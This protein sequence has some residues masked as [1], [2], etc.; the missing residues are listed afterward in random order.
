MATNPVVSL[1]DADQV[2]ARAAR[3]EL[4]IGSDV[5]ANT[6]TAALAHVLLPALAWGE[7]D[8]TVTNSERR[9]SRQRA[10]L[11]PPGEARAD[12][13]IVCEV[14]RRMGFEGFD[15]VGPHEIFD[16]HARLSA[17]RND[18]RR[19]LNLARWRLHLRPPN[20]RTAS[21]QP[22]RWRIAATRHAAPVRR[23]AL[24]HADGRARFVAAAPRVPV[25]APT[26]NSRW[27]ST[28]AACATTG[29]P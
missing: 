4:V 25:H 5:M 16:E 22:G 20:T 15:F 12:W 7:K 10:F 19:A 29:T 24:P 21:P 8:G 9:I 13:W 23:W 11:P 27:C 17:Y 1:P 18:G 14:A 3:C 6:D 26:T 2:T 28:P